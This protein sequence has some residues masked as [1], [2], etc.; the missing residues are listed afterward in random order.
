[1]SIFIEPSEP[2]VDVE[3]EAISAVVGS[4]KSRKKI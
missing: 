1:L 4:S 3:E 2:E